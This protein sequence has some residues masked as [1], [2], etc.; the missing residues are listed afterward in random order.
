MTHPVLS[1]LGLTQN[2][3]GTYLGS[4]QWSSTQDA[5]VLE[6]VNP[7]TGE[8]LGYEAQYM[9]KAQ[10]V[11][12]ETT[13]PGAD[14]KGT[15]EVI[16]ASIDIVSAKQ[17][18][19]VGDRLLPEPERELSNYVPRAPES[20]TR[21]P[22]SDFSRDD[23]STI[24]AGDAASRRREATSN[25]VM[26]GSPTSSRTMSGWSRSTSATADA[27]S[28]AVPTTTSPSASS[29]SRAIAR[30]D[31]WSSTIRTVSFSGVPSWADH[32]TGR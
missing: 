27:P 22:K 16:P 7:T 5:G 21:V 9:G 11:T 23:A 17:E 20:A 28:V 24:A 10:L 2:E 18:I 1:A 31:G 32:R 8:I 19:R 15:T 3:S 29:A 6:P 12:S 14:N 26:S 13:R 4:D 30:N 25:P